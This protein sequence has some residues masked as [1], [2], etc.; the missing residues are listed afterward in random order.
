MN[1]PPLLVS[2]SNSQ[3]YIG[4]LSSN[5][6]SEFGQ[7]IIRLIELRLPPVVSI[8]CLAVLFGFSS[9]FVWSLA[10]RP[11]RY[12]R[13]FVIPKGSGIRQ[14]QAPRVALKVIQKWIGFHIAEAWVPPQYVFG[15]VKG[16]S[17]VQAAAVHCCAKW[18]Y[19]TD[20]KN[21]FQTTKLSAVRNSVQGL[22]YSQKGAEILSMLCCL[23]GALA[24][25]SPAS[26]VLSNLVFQPVDTELAEIAVKAGLRYTRYADDVVI[27]GLGT[28][29]KELPGK[30]KHAIQ[31]HG[32]E[33][34]NEKELLVFA[35]KRLKV[36]GLV[37]HGEKPRLTK[38]YRNRIRAYKHLVASN[39][40]ASEDISRFF[41]HLAYAASIDNL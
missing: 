7:E 6:T 16:R 33:I 23:D 31:S 1:P 5:L 25:G 39:R 2:F 28:F 32:W 22:G 26:P 37:V 14:I 27:S 3:Q 8:R 34:A 18:V 4:A 35:P 19:S 9:S 13:R 38:G 41:G 36:H 17:A 10:N 20:I 40:V 30:V 15:F 12:Y 11:C 21:F 24:Q 29:P